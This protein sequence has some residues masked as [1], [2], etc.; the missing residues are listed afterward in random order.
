[1][2]DE[3]RRMRDERERMKGEKVKDVIILHS[4]A[5]ILFLVVLS[6]GCTHRSRTYATTDEFFASGVFPVP[7]EFRSGTATLPDVYAWSASLLN[8]NESADYPPLDSLKLDIDGD[9]VAELFVS[10]PAHAGN[11]GNAY[12]AFQQS[13]RGFRYLGRLGFGRIRPAPADSGG[14][15]RAVTSW[16]LGA[17]ELELTLWA[18]TAEGLREVAK[19]SLLGAG[20]S[21]TTEGNRLRDLLFQ[22]EL[23]DDTLRILFSPRREVRC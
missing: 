6:T 10:Q 18:L 15:A 16:R 11:G 13:R 7:R 22:S 20:D 17:G 23:T 3:G 21:G 19:C 8:W 4:F 12:L 1:M 2:A 14:R 5:F 9:A